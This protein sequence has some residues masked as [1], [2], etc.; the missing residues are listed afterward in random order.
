MAPTFAP[1]FADNFAPTLGANLAPTFGAA[2]GA[3]FGAT[4]GVTVALTNSLSGLATMALVTAA[5][6]LIRDFF[7]TDIRYSPLSRLLGPSPP[8]GQRGR[9]YLVHPA[10]QTSILGGL[11]VFSLCFEE[12]AENS[13]FEP[14]AG[15]AAAYRPIIK[16]SICMRLIFQPTGNS[17]EFLIPADAVFAA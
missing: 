12:L 14:R 11:E 2:L 13:V 17:Y 5:R 6:W 4:L 16:F 15:E 3:T 10:C 7:W 1:T 9:P 8:E